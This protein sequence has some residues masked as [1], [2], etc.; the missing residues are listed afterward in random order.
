MKWVDLRQ[1]IKKTGVSFIALILF[2]GLSMGNLLGTSWSGPAVQKITNK[3]YDEHAVMDFK[4]QSAD[5]FDED[6][7]RRIKNIDDV[8]AA[9]GI[10]TADAFMY[11]NG[12]KELV[13]VISST[14]G[15]DRLDIT[16]GKMPTAEDEIAVD[17]GMARMRNYSIGDSVSIDSSLK[18][19]TGYDVRSLK[20]G[21]F[22]ITAFVR[23]PEFVS[24]D[25]SAA[26]GYS[27]AY[28]RT[29]NYYFVA[30]RSAFDERMYPDGYSAVLLRMKSLEGENR[31]ADTY[32]DKTEAAADRVKKGLGGG[33]NISVTDITTTFGYYAV[34]VAGV[35]GDKVGSIFAVFFFLIGILVCYST[36][37]RIVEEEKRLIGTKL[38]NGFT[39][40]SVT[41]KYLI[42]AAIAVTLGAI[43]GVANGV[44]LSRGSQF[45]LVR[46]LTFDGSYD[47]CDTTQILKLV[48]LEY[49]IMLFIAWFASVKQ[50][51][52]KITNLLNSN[53]ENSAFFNLLSK[54][55]L[56][57][58]ASVSIQ[59]FV[60]NITMDSSRVI[61]TIVGMAG[62]IALLIAPVSLYYSILESPEVQYSDIFRFDHTIQYSDDESY[63][64][65]RDVLG[66]A[67]SDYADVYSEEALL[68]REGAKSGSVRIIAVKDEENFKKLVSLTNPKSGKDIE[69]GS[70]GVYIWQ[71][72]GKDYG[73]SAGDIM[74][75]SSYSGD[76]YE[77]E[78]AGLY[79]CYDAGAYRMF[80]TAD[81]YERATGKDFEPNAI[82]TSASDDMVKELEHIEG[83]TGCIDDYAACN[84]YYNTMK[85]G[86]LGILVMVLFLSALIAFLI[87]LN[88]NI[89]FV[90]EKKLELIVMRINGFSNA[91]AKMYIIRDNIFLSLLSAVVGV[92]GGAVLAR[93]L[94]N[95]MQMEGQNMLSSLSPKACVFGVAITMAYMVITNIIAVRPISRLDLTDISKV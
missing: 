23:H 60:Y 71:A 90:Q 15:I 59:S 37:L 78:V 11:I 1:T 52:M 9:E 4:L 28:N 89:Q 33:K 69:L 5:G 54:L 34:N 10:F 27:A 48:A 62:S 79:T 26:K 76:N 30:D 87:L 35:T 13:S 7:V 77:Y 42:Y 88:L 94:S 55:S 63:D 72:E 43:L 68:E 46:N 14:E 8:S 83:V 58:R 53:T 95:A 65:V 29:F 6:T 12:K 17:E 44:M 84:T 67:G 85:L 57:K 39:R 20:K 38:A 16:E 3:Y 22:R 93:L 25:V 47:Y 66:T 61:A 51:R 2:V 56:I 21:M 80:M 40:A 36:I 50:L 24:A 32:N 81:V 73:T 41:S 64:A 31:F 92:G 18:L 75:V 74:K 86:Y 49:A 45:M 19:L 82:L 70:D 91:A